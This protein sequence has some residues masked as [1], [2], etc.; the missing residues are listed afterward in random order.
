MFIIFKEEEF[1]KKV[2]EKKFYIISGSKCEI[3]VV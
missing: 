3:K 2:L 1:V